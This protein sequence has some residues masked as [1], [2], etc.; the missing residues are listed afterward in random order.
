MRLFFS[1]SDKQEGRSTKGKGAERRKVTV[2]KIPFIR[3]KGNIIL[4]DVS[5]AKVSEAGADRQKLRQLTQGSIGHVTICDDQ[6]PQGAV[7]L[8]PTRRRRLAA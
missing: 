5:K 2:I 4:I 3:V 6:R 7:A 8:D 1:T